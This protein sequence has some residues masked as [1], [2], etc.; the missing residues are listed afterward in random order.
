MYYL[1]NKNKKN[2]LMVPY[3]R[4]ILEFLT[5]DYRSKNSKEDNSLNKTINKL[6]KQ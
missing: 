5:K 3:I 6:S 1:K 2:E 4:Q